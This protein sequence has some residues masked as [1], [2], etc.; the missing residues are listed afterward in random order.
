MHLL[1][2][3]LDLLSPLEIYLNF[4]QLKERMNEIIENISNLFW[5]F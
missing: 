3:K 5:I 4:Q 2:K 1:K